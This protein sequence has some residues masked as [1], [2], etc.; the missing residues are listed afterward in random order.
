[1]NGDVIW[2]SISD[3]DLYLTEGSVLTGA[4]IDDETWAGE[5]GDGY[6]SLYISED[7]T[8]TVTGDSTVTN[9]YAAGTIQDPD[10]NPVTIQGTD[11]TTY[12]E[13]TSPYT[14]TTQTYSETL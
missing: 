11:G 7:S 8:W 5:G 1:M 2:D 9:L 10:G 12:Q 3:L 14:I 6:C 13:G 4:V